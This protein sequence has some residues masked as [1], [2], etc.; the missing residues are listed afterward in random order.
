M[1]TWFA[2]WLK[3]AWFLDLPRVN[4]PLGS[5]GHRT[6]RM[7]RHACCFSLPPTQ[8]GNIN[9]PAVFTSYLTLTLTF[10]LK[11]P[12]NDL[13]HSSNWYKQYPWK[14]RPNV[15]SLARR[16]NWW[17]WGVEVRVTWNGIAMP[18]H[19]KVSYKT[20]SVVLLEK[21]NKQRGGMMKQYPEVDYFLHIAHPQMLYFSN[22]TAVSNC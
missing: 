15:H 6:F 3:T 19:F 9:H 1:E 11:S 5:I 13:H 22:T 10:S 16:C 8:P 7:P 18:W 21:N 2:I 12:I 17:Q 14:C 20:F 4:V